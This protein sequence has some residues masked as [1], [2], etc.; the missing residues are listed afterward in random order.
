MPYGEIAFSDRAA[1]SSMRGDRQRADDSD[2]RDD[3][4]DNQGQT[5]EINRG[6]R[7]DLAKPR[8][9]LDRP[10]KSWMCGHEMRIDE[11]LGD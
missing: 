7:A 9:G 8:T 3:K 1:A 2:V 6:G 11:H 4:K 5:E 10:I